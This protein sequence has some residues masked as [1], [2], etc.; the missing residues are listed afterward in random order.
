MCLEPEQEQWTMQNRKNGNLFRLSIPVVG[1]ILMFN[2]LG[3]AGYCFSPHRHFSPDGHDHIHPS[4]LD[5]ADPCARAMDDHY[6]A[7]HS[8]CHDSHAEQSDCVR[9]AV[10]L[11]VRTEAGQNLFC[12]CPLVSDMPVDAR[13]PNRFFTQSLYILPPQLPALRTIILLA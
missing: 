12:P 4:H 1:M 7:T 6:T 5:F 9:V 11:E 3:A 8:L 10:V 2:P 13:N